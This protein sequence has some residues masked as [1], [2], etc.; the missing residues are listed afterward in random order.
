[1]IISKMIEWL[2]IVKKQTGDVEVT[3]LDDETGTFER[4]DGGFFYTGGTFPEFQLYTA[5]QLDDF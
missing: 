4:V 2:E 1:M 3:M 5:R